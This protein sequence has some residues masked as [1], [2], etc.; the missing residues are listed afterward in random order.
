[1]RF[2]HVI[3]PNTREAYAPSP[4][5][6]NLIRERNR[7]V[8]PENLEWGDD[9][10]PSLVT[11]CIIAISKQFTRNPLLAELPEAERD[12]L[13]EIL[14][15]DLSLDLV[16][17]LIDVSLVDHSINIREAGVIYFINIYANFISIS[18]IIK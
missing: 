12:Q 11:F 8:F 3:N 4:A 16:V 2:P 14:P 10:C 17:P 18:I 13:L 7:R 15:T 1:M 5:A 9:R 6:L